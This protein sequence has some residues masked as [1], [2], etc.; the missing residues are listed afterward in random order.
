VSVAAA[1]VAA[2]A[3]SNERRSS[4]GLWETAWYRLRRDRL[5][6]AAIIVL[7]TLCSFS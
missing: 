1:R 6:I 4:A 5:T 7:M 3:S 2:P